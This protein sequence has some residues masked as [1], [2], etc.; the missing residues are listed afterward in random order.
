MTDATGER[1]EAPSSE[2][3]SQA[4]RSGGAWAV[5]QSLLSK[6]VSVVGQVALAWF[7]VEDD[8]GIVATAASVLAL[9]LFFNPPLMAD[10]LLQRKR[11][12]AV[13]AA[14]AFWLTIALAALT[15]LVF[16]CAAPFVAAYYENPRLTGILLV[17]A[18]TPIAAA[19][20]PV[21]LARLRIDLRLGAIARWSI[22]MSVGTTVATVALAALGFGAYSIAIPTALVGLVASY[23]FARRAG[24]LVGGALTREAEWKP[25]L[26]DYAAVCAG[27]YAHTLGLF[28]DYLALSIFATTE[29]LG[30]YYFAFR[31]SAQINALFAYNVSLALQPVLSHL[32]EA[33]ERQ[34]LAFLKACRTIALPAIPLCLLQAALA[35]PI[36]RLLFEA[37]WIP[38]IPMLMIL[39]V[40]QAFSITTGPTQA[41]LKA[42]SRF[43]TYT[44]WQSAQS[45]AFL[46]AVFLAAGL[47]G[48]MVHD[49]TGLANARAVCVAIAVAI[50]FAIFCPLGLWIAVRKR[51]AGLGAVAR[52]FAPPLM[53]G[54][55]LGGAALAISSALP[56]TRLGAGLALALAGAASIPIGL[57]GA[58]WLAPDELAAMRSMLRRRRAA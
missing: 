45:A 43:G 38:S 9:F 11:R 36:V 26:R 3:L 55:V 24:T 58:R 6:A 13:D 25:M 21:S 30:L 49:A 52:V 46:P 54:V 2:R 48:P 5:V 17:T 56:T 15:S 32:S 12:F 27:Q 16:A 42:Q 40:A 8:F 7:L 34:S 28:A 44:A 29:E 50:V 4:A 14:A 41:M 1:D 31:M 39:S 47:I 22:V 37:R 18:V 19:L 53:I 35:G 51:G 57:L 20:Q 23:G 10:V 33:P